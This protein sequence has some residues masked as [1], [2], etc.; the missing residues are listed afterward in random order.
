MHSI[1]SHKKQLSSSS[2]VAIVLFCSLLI[3]RDVEARTYTN[4]A[5][6]TIDAELTGM[7][8]ETALLKLK[9]G[10]QVKVPTNKLTYE[11]QH[12]DNSWRTKA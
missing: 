1:T 3:S 8:K 5:G 2:L 4:T 12:K 10:K 6:K 11:I 7:K 9:S